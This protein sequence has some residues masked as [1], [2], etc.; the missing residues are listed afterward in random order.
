MNIIGIKKLPT[1]IITLTAIKPGLRTLRF[2]SCDN[3]ESILCS[4]H[5]PWLYFR[6]VYNETGNVIDFHT[7]TSKHQYQIHNNQI[8]FN[9]AHLNF[10]NVFPIIV[11]NKF[12]GCSVCMGSQFTLLPP[13]LSIRNHI[14]HYINSFF[15]TEF[16][17]LPLIVINGSYRYLNKITYLHA[18]DIHNVN[19][20]FDL[21]GT[22]AQYLAET[23]GLTS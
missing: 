16:T 5:F 6:I 1:K 7:Y 4:V 21:T 18:A 15:S 12:V 2:L 8:R 20:E 23:I 11:N 10:P 9:G 19:W 3:E 22:D 17:G 13:S 14:F